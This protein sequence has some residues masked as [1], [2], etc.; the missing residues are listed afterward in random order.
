MISRNYGRLVY[1]STGLSRP[2]R[3]GMIVS[4]RPDAQGQAVYEAFVS[5]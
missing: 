4:R 5:K 3:A 1:L 2:P